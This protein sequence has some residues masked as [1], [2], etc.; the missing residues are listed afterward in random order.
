MPAGDPRLDL[1]PMNLERRW[2]CHSK[3]KGRLEFRESHPAMILELGAREARRER[4]GGAAIVPRD[5][6]E[7]RPLEPDDPSVGLAMIKR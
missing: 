3:Q 6:P 1:E 5:T 7:P 4:A 2:T